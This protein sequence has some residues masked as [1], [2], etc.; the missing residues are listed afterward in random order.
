[1]KSNLFLSV[2]I[3]AYNEE[4]NLKKGALAEVVN[5]L[6]KQPYLW[7]IIVVDDGSVDET[8]EFVKKLVKGQEK[9]TLIKN[10]HQ[11]KAATVITGMLQA[12]GQIVLFTD[13]DQATPITQIDKL[14]P[15]FEDGF[16]IAIGSRRGRKGAPLT[17]K[18][19]A[20]G[21]S[22]LRGLFLGLPFFDTQCGFKSFKQEV[23]QNIFHQLKIYNQK[24]VIRGSA[25]TAGFDIETLFLARKL[26]YK[27]AEVPVD[28]NYQTTGRVNPI[29][30]SIAGLKGII[31]VRLNDWR[32]EYDK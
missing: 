19:M 20:N 3:P 12:K 15:K 17:R 6:S 26:G 31:K 7:E 22:L 28:W 11:G 27:V 24:K 1:M 5:F 29:K 18:L 9:I 4:K 16:D 13:M 8:V 14:L 23:A 2:V 30:D 10:P 32:G 25:V 21:F